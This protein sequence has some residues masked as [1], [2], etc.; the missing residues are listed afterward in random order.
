MKILS[1]ACMA[2]AL[3]APCLALGEPPSMPPQ[4]LHVGDVLGRA[5]MVV[6]SSRIY[7]RYTVD[8]KGQRSAVDLWRRTVT[9][10][11]H[12]GTRM[13]RINQRWDGDALPAGYQVAQDSWFDPLDMRPREHVREVTRDGHY[14]AR[15]YAFLP[16]HVTGTPLATSEQ[17]MALDVPA[18]EPVFNFETD[19]EL[20]QA[21]PLALGYTVSIPFYDPGQEPPA[22]YIFKVVGEENIPGPD[23]RMLATW[24][25]SCDYNKPDGPVQ[26]FWYSKDTQVMLREQVTIDGVS[27]IKTL[28]QGEPAPLDSATTP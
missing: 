18:P 4:V 17:K 16:G 25:V 26:R 24:V 19:M 11:Q 20:L 3:S 10:E 28:L 21:L 22:R 13:M 8:A 9:F 7:L 15:H 2:A 23:G 27:H 14:S 5:E 12:A 6:P 1:F